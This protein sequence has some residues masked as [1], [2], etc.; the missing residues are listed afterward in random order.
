MIIGIKNIGTKRFVWWG[1]IFH[2][3]GM[4]FLATLLM[5]Y[6]GH[7]IHYEHLKIVKFMETMFEGLIGGNFLFTF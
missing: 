6:F 4:S 1:M 5:I 2:L 3:M 7:D